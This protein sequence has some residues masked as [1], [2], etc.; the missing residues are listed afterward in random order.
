VKV[1]FFFDTKNTI[2]KKQEIKKLDLLFD[3][4]VKNVKIQNIISELLK[5]LCINVYDYKTS[6]CQEHWK[7]FI[8][9]IVDLFEKV[10][11]KY[12]LV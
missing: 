2:V 5:G 11:K 6:F 12:F 10:Q 8:N 4:L 1:E 3:I 9:K 7:N